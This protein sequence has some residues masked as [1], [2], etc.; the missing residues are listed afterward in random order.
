MAVAAPT[1]FPTPSADG[2]NADAR[3]R[4]YGL[5][6]DVRAEAQD[7]ETALSVILQTNSL[8]DPETREREM[9]AAILDGQKV[10]SLD[11]GRIAELLSSLRYHLDQYADLYDWAGDEATH[12]ENCWQRVWLPDAA[13]ATAKDFE[14]TG[15]A[16]RLQASTQALAE[17]I[18]HA[19]LV[20]IPSRLNDHLKGL[21]V[22]G[23]LDFHEAFR[24]ELPRDEDR[25]KLL[26]YIHAHPASVQGVVDPKQGLVYKASRSTGRRL[27]SYAL[28]VASAAIGLPA[29]FVVAHLGDWFNLDG[30]KVPSTRSSELLV[31]YMFLALGAFG[32]LLI[33]TLKTS[34][35]GANRGFLVL[36]DLFLWVHVRETS[37][38]LSLLALPLAIVVMAFSIDDVQW[39][40]AFFVGYS[41]DSFL[42][43]FLDR[44]AATVGAKTAAIKASL[45]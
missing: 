14:A 10:L 20:T 43:L 36:G 35:S 12:I 26:Q 32:H 21:R 23:V 38:A 41:I 34:R 6:R 15:V 27:V 9:T 11:Q 4:F 19:A 30:W 37:I 42:G 40:T 1:N 8:S 33:E 18:Y 24:D 22:G 7:L 44:F 17:L 2:E 28:L 39:E 5:V 29:V 31:A 25:Q 16:R 45:A 13:V 3:R